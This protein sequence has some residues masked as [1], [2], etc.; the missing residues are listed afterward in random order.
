MNDL[1]SEVIAGIP[2]ELATQVTPATRVADLSVET[3]RFL[4]LYGGL[5]KW[6]LGSH[7]GGSRKQHLKEK[8]L[9]LWK[10]FGLTMSHQQTVFRLLN[11]ALAAGATVVAA[12]VPAALEKWFG[13]V[14][15]LTARSRSA[16][17]AARDKCLDSRFSRTVFFLNSD[18]GVSCQT[19]D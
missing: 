2:D 5:K 9:L 19:R 6:L 1:V 12:G 8:L 16:A 7:R 13:N 10:P 4:R 14:L 17:E 18:S 11:E 3:A 15:E